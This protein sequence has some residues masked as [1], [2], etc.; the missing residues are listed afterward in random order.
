MSDKK[1]N[2]VNLCLS[3]GHVI[4]TCGGMAENS[5]IIFGDG[6]G[7]DNIIACADYEA[8]AIRDPKYAGQEI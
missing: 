4:P 1:E 2:E 5:N 3:C 7:L 6:V 8:V